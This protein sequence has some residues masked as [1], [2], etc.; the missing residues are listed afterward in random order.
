MPHHIH[1]DSDNEEPDRETPSLD[2][3]SAAAQTEG[4]ATRAPVTTS[5]TGGLEPPAQPVDQRLETTPAGH[6]RATGAPHAPTG[7]PL[8]WRGIETLYQH[9]SPLAPDGKM[10]EAG[11]GYAGPL[12]VRTVWRTYRAR[13]WRVPGLTQVY[14]GL[15]HCSHPP[16]WVWWGLLTEPVP[17]APHRR[18]PSGFVR[19]MRTPPRSR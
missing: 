15:K 16:G 10:R 19:T 8:R 9:R 14:V 12:R 11:D 17:T 13:W 6:P 1:W 3:T 5:A 18:A 4:H 7:Q 2:Q